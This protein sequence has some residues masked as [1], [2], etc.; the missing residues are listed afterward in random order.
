MVWPAWCHWS[1]HSRPD[2]LTDWADSDS[3]LSST[4][5]SFH[6]HRGFRVLLPYMIIRAVVIFCL[7]KS[8]LYIRDKADSIEV[9]LSKFNRIIAFRISFT[10]FPSF[11]L[12]HP[13]LLVCAV[14]HPHSRREC[15][16]LFRFVLAQTALNYPPRPQHG[17]L[18]ADIKPFTF[19]KLA[20]SCFIRLFYILL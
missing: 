4:H 20:C 17:H 3:S 11:T 12:V 10:F 14:N 13:S 19:F 16:I 7:C 18:L 1:D 5:V 8:T 2:S 6:M 15:G 9:S